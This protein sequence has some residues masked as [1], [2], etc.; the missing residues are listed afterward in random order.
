MFSE[1]YDLNEYWKFVE[2]KKVFQI[3]RSTVFAVYRFVF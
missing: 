2:K 1:T 3:I